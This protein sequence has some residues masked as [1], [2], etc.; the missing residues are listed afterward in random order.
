MIVLQ[1]CRAARYKSDRDGARAGSRTLNLEI[2][3]GKAN[4][5]GHGALYRVTL[6]SSTV[7]NCASGETV[8]K[9]WTATGRRH[10]QWAQSQA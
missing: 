1:R 7:A 2:K 4:L 6:S 3:S 9:M 5:L 8:S 10:D